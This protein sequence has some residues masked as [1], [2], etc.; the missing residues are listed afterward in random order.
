MLQ[1]VTQ[2]NEA[3]LVFI[4]KLLGI[5]AVLLLAGRVDVWLARGFHP[6]PDRPHD[7][8]RG[9]VTDF[10]GWTSPTRRR[11]ISGDLILDHAFALVLVLAR[12]G[13]TLALLPGL[14]ETAIPAV[15]KAGMVLT[16]TILLL[17]IVEPALPPRPES[18][19]ALGLMVADRTGQRALVRLA[20]AGSD[21]AACRSR[22]S[23]SPISRVSRT[24]CN[25]RPDLGAQ[26]TA[27]S[28]LYDVAVP[29]LILSP[30]LYTAAAVRAGW[31]LSV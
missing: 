3:T 7:R 9:I 10:A 6:L 26:T 21:H 11:G 18:E 30:G 15:V 24:C 14:G 2:I 4:P 20:G 28:R 1:A 8:D 19:V 12:V 27:I 16:L 31:I 29:A 22:A 17:P 25:R 13:A 23:T 5:G